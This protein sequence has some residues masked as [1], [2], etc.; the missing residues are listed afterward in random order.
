M[1]IGA[2]I[3][4]CELFPVTFMRLGNPWAFR[5]TN[6][7]ISTFATRKKRWKLGCPE[8]DEDRIH[9]L[10]ETTA[11]VVETVWRVF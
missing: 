6:G 10:V 3:L 1:G 8:H 9:Q 11:A 5:S 2:H 7:A 4:S